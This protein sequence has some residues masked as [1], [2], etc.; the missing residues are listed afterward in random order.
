MSDRPTERRSRERV[1]VRV[2]VTVKPKDGSA[3]QT[4]YTRDLNSN[5]VF[6]Y[7]ESRFSEG[8]QMEVVLIL[9]SELTF[10]EKRWVC[11]QVSIVRV[12]K[13]AEGIFGVAA[14]IE[15]FE[16]LPEIPG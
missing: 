8:S 12:Q 1:P 16:I 7:T 14:T 2:R 10:G 9:P 3:E 4:A 15:K 13:E 11:C 5:G 6:F